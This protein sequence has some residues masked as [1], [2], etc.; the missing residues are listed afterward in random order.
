MTTEWGRFLLVAEQAN[1]QRISIEI[2]GDTNIGDVIDAIETFLIAAGFHRDH[3]T[4]VF[5]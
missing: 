1:G 4:E 3:V 5:K 2:P